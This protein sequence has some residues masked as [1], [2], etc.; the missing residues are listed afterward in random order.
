[1][2]VPRP[3]ML[4]ILGLALLAGAFLVTRSGSSESVTQPSHSP[5]KPALAPLSRVKPS[6][7]AG[8]ADSPTSRALAH[9]APHAAR[10]RAGADAEV[11]DAVE[12][13][14]KA[15]GSGKVVVLFFTRPGTA[16]D[17]ATAAAV[18]SLKGMKRVAVFDA[19][20]DRIAQYRPIIANVGVTQV[21]AVVVVRPGQR[22][23][24]FQGFVDAG[25]LRQN[26]ADALR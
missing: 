20:L 5:Q 18:H 23:V 4:A 9:A 3:V 13:A 11:P 10:S 8:R 15:L 21:P 2:A 12:D 16:D 19:S 17:S 7:A 6:G 1:M 22:A 26:V 24:L 25:T 14:A